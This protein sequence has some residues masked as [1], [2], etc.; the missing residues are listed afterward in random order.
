LLDSNIQVGRGR[1]TWAPVATVP[2]QIETIQQEISDERKITHPELSDDVLAELNVR[3]NEEL[4]EAQTVEV[5]L[6]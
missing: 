5:I 1:I 3:L 4:Q 6:Y 2:E